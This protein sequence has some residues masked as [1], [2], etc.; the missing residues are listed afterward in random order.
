[1]TAKQGVHFLRYSLR[2]K[3]RNLTTSLI[4]ASNSAEWDLRSVAL[5]LVL[6]AAGSI[7]FVFGL[8]TILIQHQ[9]IAGGLAGVAILL[10]HIQPNLDI[11]WWYLLL[12]MPLVWLGWKRIGKRFMLLTVFGMV[13][14]S[15]AAV[16]I[17][18]PPLAIREPFLALITAGVV[19][20]LGAG[21]VL[22]S[23]G[24]AGGLDILAVHFKE[25]FGFSIG[26][27]GFALNAL[28]LIA[29]VWLFSLEAALYSALFLF[30]C[31]R[32]VD[33]VMVGINPHKV[34]LVISDHAETIGQSL[35]SQ[36]NCRITFLKGEGGYARVEKKVI[37]TVA[38]QM[39]IPR[40][41]AFILQEDPEAFVVVNAVSEVTQRKTFAG[42]TSCGN[43]SSFR[44]FNEQPQ[45]NEVCH[46]DTYR[47]DGFP[48]S[49][50]DAVGGTRT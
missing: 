17:K 34:M 24:S 37:Y 7:V 44:D 31:S 26:A 9:L 48:I 21:L 45:V 42:L 46:A 30:I 49:T 35:L 47:V 1:M 10:N 40:L 25:Q 4:S 39:K 27:V 13:F 18:L 2:P 29:G 8:N 16:W 41:K 32:V 50:P 15:L 23:N 14:F 6:I 28:L 19:C 22:R 36:H 33:A 3:Q 12:N 5:D 20:G 38:P 11:G 43:A